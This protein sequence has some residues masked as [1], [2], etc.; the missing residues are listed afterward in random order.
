MTEQFGIRQFW[1]PIF[2]ICTKAQR[3]RTILSTSCWHAYNN[4]DRPSCTS[5]MFSSFFISSCWLHQV[6]ILRKPGVYKHTCTP[7][8]YHLFLKCLFAFM[9]A[10]MCMQ[11]LFICMSW[12][13]GSLC[14]YISLG[15]TWA[16]LPSR[17]LRTTLFNGP[18][19]SAHTQREPKQ[20]EREK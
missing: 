20:R 6:N 7:W 16:M 12:V 3:Y 14:V 2:L 19:L 13:F 9:G 15:C 1:N 18:S 10:H 4:E 5:Q 11:L 8:Q 17:R